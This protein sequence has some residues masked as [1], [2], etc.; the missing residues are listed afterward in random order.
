MNKPLDFGLENS[1]I[2]S[3]K[4]IPKKTVGVTVRRDLLALAREH[5][6]NLS[7][8]LE[9]SLIQLSEPQHISFPF[10]TG[11]PFSKAKSV[12]LRPSID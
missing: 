7:K 6:V 8:I 11:F 3:S 5:G 12:V 4:S 9:I 2:H 1:S 10:S